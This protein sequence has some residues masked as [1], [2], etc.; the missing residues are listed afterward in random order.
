M[1]K[2]FSWYQRWYLTAFMAVLLLLTYFSWWLTDRSNS[3]I[4]LIGAIG[5]A[6]LAW[7]ERKRKK[8]FDDL[9]YELEG[10]IVDTEKGGGFDHVC[11]RT[12]KRV[13]KILEENA[14]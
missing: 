2:Y 3:G 13:Q 5:W 6:F 4:P 7:E 11:L 1:K 12:V 9:Y 14:R 10:V 8:L